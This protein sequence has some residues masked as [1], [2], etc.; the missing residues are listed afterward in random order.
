MSAEKKSSDI[1]HN[2]DLLSDFN[3]L[4]PEEG[5]SFNALEVDGGDNDI[6]SLL[7]GLEP[8]S[9]GSIDTAETPAGT[10]IE[11]AKED[12]LG[13][14]LDELEEQ[15]DEITGNDD[16][17]LEHLLNKMVEEVRVEVAHDLDT[18]TGDLDLH[19]GG[20]DEVPEITATT[21]KTAL[22]TDFENIADS[23]KPP[24]LEDSYTQTLYAKNA[25]EIA[26]ASP[27]K[28]ATTN[29]YLLLIAALG[30]GGASLWLT[31][32]SQQTIVRQSTTID[33]LQKEQKK[34]A[35]SVLDDAPYNPIVAPN[36][37]S[38]SDLD[39]RLND[40][41]K[42]VE[43]PLSQ[44][45]ATTSKESIDKLK[46]RLQQIE[47]SLG[48]LKDELTKRPPVV[49]ATTPPPIAKTINGDTPTVKI[50]AINLLSL[51]SS[52]GANDAVKRLQMAGIDASSSR[53][54]AKDGK[55]W[56]RVSIAGF[57][58][59]EEANAYARMMPIIE[60]NGQHWIT[61]Q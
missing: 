42:M 2:D 50:W 28:L 17:E 31:L 21:F 24:F 32:Q 43:G 48:S 16:L 10:P 30:V 61:D 53:F 15:V 19:A 52:K 59:R 27:S 56:Y 44:I 54:V 4:F 40:L 23:P 22:G 35:R 9:E 26:T 13:S 46:G 57:N 36:S 34:E 37:S 47:Q 11:N 14:Q 45:N 6:D 41:S 5:D 39:Q 8:L 1:D 60:G 25:A 49:A 55:T 51:S 18:D 12:N 29:I 58:S 20:A 33:K 38:I 7:D 3:D